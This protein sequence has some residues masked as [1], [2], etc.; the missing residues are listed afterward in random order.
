[1]LPAPSSLLFSRSKLPRLE[2]G[3]LSANPARYRVAC[4]NAIFADFESASADQ[5]E[6]Q[7]WAAHLKVNNVFRKENRSL[8]K[9]AKERVVELRKLQKKYMQ[10]IKS[11]QR[12]YRQYILNLDAQF[13]GIP[14]LRKVARTWKDDGTPD[15]PFFRRPRSL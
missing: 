15:A 2:L 12:F 10:F 3:G 11:S 14:E 7:L 13:E 5:M 1:M 9:H 4:E 6:P 8:K